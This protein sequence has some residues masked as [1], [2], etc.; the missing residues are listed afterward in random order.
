ML[1]HLENVIRKEDAKQ[2]RDNSKHK[3]GKPKERYTEK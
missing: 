2:H 1:Y 3:H